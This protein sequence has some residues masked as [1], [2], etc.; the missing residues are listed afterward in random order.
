MILYDLDGTLVDTSQDITQ[1][2]NHMLNQMGHEALSLEHVRQNIG[3]GVFELVA[4]C[5]NSGSKEH[6]EEGM[7]LFR[8]FYREHLTDQSTLYPAAQSVLNYFKKHHQA[9]ITNKPEPFTK[10]LLGAL[11]LSEFFSHVIS[12]NIGYPRKPDPAGITF[13]MEKLGVAKA[14]AIFIGDSVV[15]MQA[16]RNA[17]ILTVAI[18]HGYGEEKDLLD[19][20]PDLIVEDFNEFMECAERYGW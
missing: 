6:M 9:I 20:G 15:D 4:G 10:E 14:E 13:V 17:G 2:V 3:R 1:A 16:G 18:K 11:G 12:G 8:S 19:T 5:L 7:T